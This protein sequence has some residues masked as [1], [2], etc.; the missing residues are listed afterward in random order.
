MSILPSGLRRRRAPQPRTGAAAVR[1]TAPS[2]WPF[3]LPALAVYVV[4]Y[5]GP[6]LFGVYVSFMRW[7]GL[8][9]PMTFAGLANYR[10]ML[11]D[12]GMHTV[13]LNTLLLMVVGLVGIGIVTLIAMLVLQRMRGRRI[14]RVVVFVPY[15]ISPIAIGVAFG[16]LLDPQGLLNVSLS[17][18]GLDSLR[19]SWL[20]PDLVFK[21]VMAAVTW[22][23]S[24]L[25]IVL[26]LAVID[27]IPAS[28]Y[29]SADLAGATAWQRLW[30]V[31]LPMSRG[32]LGVVVTLCLI[33]LMKVFDIVYTLTGASGTPPYSARTFAVEQYVTMSPF[34]GRPDFGYGS[35]LG[36]A[37]VVLVT[38]LVVL[39]RRLLRSEPVEY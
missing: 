8:G 25:A 32:V 28:L 18:L 1:A 21:C 23:L 27:S 7:E 17:S 4:L 13:L 33:Q 39:L 12:S 19:Q 29:E 11:A 20:G 26:L 36:V 30:Y 5:L 2:L 22:T 9:S 35:A 3:V 15:L 6:A 34:G 24:G 14:V 10:R 38:I 37:F 31:T 16:F